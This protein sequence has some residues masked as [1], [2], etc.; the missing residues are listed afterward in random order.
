ML[1]ARDHTFLRNEKAKNT[2]TKEWMNERNM[3]DIEHVLVFEQFKICWIWEITRFQ[4]EWLIVSIILT[5]SM[6]TKQKKSISGAKKFDE[7]CREWIS[8]VCVCVFVYGISIIVTWIVTYAPRY[9]IHT[10]IRNASERE[11]QKRTRVESEK[12]KERWTNHRFR[13]MIG[14]HL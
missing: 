13:S 4:L 7:C 6:G 11:E 12:S 1:G 2:K 8:R 14:T 10:K 9:S 5:L 3:D